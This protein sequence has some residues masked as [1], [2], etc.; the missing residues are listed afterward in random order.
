MKHL[1][2]VKDF[3]SCYNTRNQIRN[4]TPEN[5]SRE[6][7][8]EGSM[9]SKEIAENLKGGSMI[10]KMFEEGNR[11]RALYGADHVYDFSLGNP[12][13]EP[14]CRNTAGHPGIGCTA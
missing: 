13:G 12:D 10:R 4:S 2:M 7:K 8:E 1:S 11:L 14:A 5:V 9:V 6:T 3:Y